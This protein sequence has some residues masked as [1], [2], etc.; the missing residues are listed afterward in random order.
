MSF[1]DFA[2][3]RVN[4]GNNGVGVVDYSGGGDSTKFVVFYDKPIPNPRKSAEMGRPWSDAVVYCRMQDPGDNLQVNDVPA[5]EVLKRRFPRQWQAYLE[6][7]G[8]EQPGTQLDILFPFQVEIV[9]NLRQMKIMTV[10]ALANV[11]DTVKGQI[12][13]GANEWQQKAKAFLDKAAG[14][15]VFA[16]MERDKAE[17]R[18][19]NESLRHQIE[20][21]RQMMVQQGI[22]APINQP[23]V[24]PQNT[25][26]LSQANLDTH[27]RGPGRPRKEP[28]SAGDT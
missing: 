20:E 24:F 21:I 6:G 27:K 12:G 13:I 25:A 3:G 11:T 14:G 8:E 17:L 22:N 28:F 9:A 15:A 1:T 7:H 4:M 2:Q 23:Q 16:Q 5:S 19:E 10:E 18:A 26:A